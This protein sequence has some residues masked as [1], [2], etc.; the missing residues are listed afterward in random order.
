MMAD[1]RKVVNR[2][3]LL[4]ILDYGRFFF[5]LLLFWFIEGVKPIEC[6]FYRLIAALS[7][8][9]WSDLKLRVIVLMSELVSLSGDHPLIFPFDE[10]SSEAQFHHR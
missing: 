1:L 5:E 6:L 2:R 9:T 7:R 10:A 4:L 8:T 3:K